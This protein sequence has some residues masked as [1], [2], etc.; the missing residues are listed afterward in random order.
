MGT[1]QP[2]RERFVSILRQSLPVLRNEGSRVM[3]RPFGTSGI[4]NAHSRFA[5]YRGRQR[6][7]G[8]PGITN[9][10]LAGVKPSATLTRWRA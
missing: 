1:L 6:A 9:V 5:R 8:G 3:R 4:R 10:I 7:Q 2:G